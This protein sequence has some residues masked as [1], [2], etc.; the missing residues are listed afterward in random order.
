MRHLSIPSRLLLA[1][2]TLIV[3]PAT[4]Q[5]SP[6]GAVARYAQTRSPLAERAAAFL[7]EHRP[8]RD[9]DI[10]AR[11]LIDTVDLAVAAREEFPWASQVPEAIFLNDVLP[12]AV[13]DETRENWRPAMLERCRPIVAGAT[14]ASEAAQALNRELFDL[15]D[16]HY[17][18]GRKKPNQSPS[19][20][21]VQ[22]RAT[23]TG[24][25]I[26]LVDACRAVGIPARVAGVAS[27]HDKR[28]NHTW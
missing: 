10:D 26:L 9:L 3:V 2:A 5:Q 12:Y 4:G 13:L 27:W 20:S 15:I 14:S 8:R 17:N 1:F 16:V 25:S 28:G 23:C 24:L 18:T 6:W 11:I 19:E 7:A 22:G 21:I